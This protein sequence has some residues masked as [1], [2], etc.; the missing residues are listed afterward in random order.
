MAFISSWQNCKGRPNRYTKTGEINLLKLHLNFFT[1]S[2]QIILCC[3]CILS[4]NLVNKNVCQSLTAHR[5]ACK[6]GRVIKSSLWISAYAYMFIRSAS[7]TLKQCLDIFLRENYADYIKVVK[8]D[9][10][11][12][13]CNVASNIL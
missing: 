4:Q 6:L 8:D 12:G 1:H 10:T 13:S 7:I 9:K 2:F 11:S 3:F 5:L